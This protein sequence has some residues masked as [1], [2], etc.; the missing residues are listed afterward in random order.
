MKAV[1]RASGGLPADWDINQVFATADA[2]VGVPVMSELYAQMK[3]Q[4]FAPDLP[5]LWRSLGV[6]REGDTV[7]INDQAP[8][9]A[10]RRAIFNDE[11]GGEP[12]VQ[13]PCGLGRGQPLA[14]LTEDA[15]RGPHP[16]RALRPA[17][18]ADRTRPVPAAT[19]ASAGGRSGA[20]GSVAVVRHWRTSTRPRIAGDTS[21]A[22]ASGRR[23]TCSAG[24]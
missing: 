17:T 2:A 10:I 5:A 21:P 4:P 14:Q 7:R 15:R 11:P 12:A 19:P 8:L 23:R 13:Q 1:L 16:A 22:A 9:A 24:Q 20:S 6:E 3:D 18:G